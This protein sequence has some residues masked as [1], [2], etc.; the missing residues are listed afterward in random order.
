MSIKTFP[1]TRVLKREDLPVADPNRKPHDFSY[2][3][4]QA[5]AHTRAGYHQA[6][7]TDISTDGTLVVF[8]DEEK[9]YRAHNGVLWEKDR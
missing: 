3:A 4:N 8:S 7:T 9:F 2:P 6:G 1:T 5:A